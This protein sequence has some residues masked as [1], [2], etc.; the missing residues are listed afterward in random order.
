M[1]KIRRCS[2]QRASKLRA[3]SE[4][5]RAFYDA[6]DRLLALDDKSRISSS[7]VEDALRTLS[8]VVNGANNNCS[9]EFNASLLRAAREYFRQVSLVSV[10]EQ[11][12]ET[13]KATE[14]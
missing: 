10:I 7:E 14:V 12:N 13:H 8:A 2:E 6:A 3:Q 11:E 9:E 4:V 5:V 1:T